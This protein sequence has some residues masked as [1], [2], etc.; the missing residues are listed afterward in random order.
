[1]STYGQI[2]A[3]LL[4]DLCFALGVGESAREYLNVQ[5]VLME[6]WNEREIP[7]L[8]P[9]PSR[10]GDDHSPFEYSLQFARDSVELRLLLEAQAAAPSLHGNQRAAIALNEKLAKRYGVDL[11]RFSRLRD[12]FCPEDP[13]GPFS[14]WHAACFEPSGKPDFKVYLNPR[15]HCGTSAVQLVEEAA[16]RSGLSQSA[17]ALIR[18]VVALGGE[19]NYFSLDLAERLGS[20]VKIYFSHPD[21]RVEELER[22]LALAPGNRPGD[23]SRFCTEIAGRKQRFTE[24]PVCYCFSFRSGADA[25]LAVTF[26]LPVAHYVSSDELIMNR[27]SAFM[28]SESMPVERYRRAVAAMARRDIRTTVGLHSYFSFRREPKG[29]KVT[30]YLSPELFAAPPSQYPLTA[31]LVPRATRQG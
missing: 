3:R 12:L 27:I 17:H 6:P 2:S 24:K 22:V 18:R 16:S 5:S 20:R 30:V 10:I 31:D 19:P 21:A 7:A 23:V 28:T 14:L 9:Y 4:R 25:P 11:T 26:H 8:S 15:V 29:L 13:Q 1:M